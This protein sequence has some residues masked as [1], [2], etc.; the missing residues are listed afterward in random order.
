MAPQSHTAR[1]RSSVSLVKWSTEVRASI[2]CSENQPDHVV[3]AGDLWVPVGSLDNVEFASNVNFLEL[4]DE[5]DRR[6]AIE[7][8][9]AGRDLDREQVVGPVTE[10][11]HDFPG[12]RAVFLH[13]GAIARQ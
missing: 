13:I 10:P 1:A 11:L 6:V 7:R 3:P 5:H 8:N 9:V 2:R 12:F 4:V